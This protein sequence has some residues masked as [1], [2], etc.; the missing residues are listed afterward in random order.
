MWIKDEAWGNKVQDDGGNPA[1]ALVNRATGLALQHAKHESEQVRLVEYD[2]NNLDESL[3]WT[4]S[5]DLGGGYHAVRKASDTSLNL[6][7]W[8]ADADS[9]GVHDGTV[10]TLY[11]WNK[12]ANQLWKIDN[13]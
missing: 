12:G 3:L 4:L 2:P 1:F 6:D 10:L 8:K 5:D 13:L 9:G 7:A 11:K